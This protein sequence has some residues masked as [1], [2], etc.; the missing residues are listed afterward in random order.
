MSIATRNIIRL[1]C[2][3]AAI[4]LAATLLTFTVDPLQLFRP[5][6]FFTAMYS[7]D[8]RMQNAGLIRSQQFDT[9][10]MG[11]SLSIHVRPS[12][13]DRTLGVRSVKLAM[14]GSNSREHIFVLDTAME[15]R[16]RRVLWQMDDWIF[17][18]APDV[19]AY[20][21]ANLYR[22][23]VSGLAQYLLSGAM[24]R[25]SLW[26]ALR[27]FPTLA[28]VIT[29]LTNGV[30]FRFP[31]AEVDDINA[32]RR[33]L[34]IGAMYNKP[35]ALAGFRSIIDPSRR[36]IL[37]GGYD[38]DAMIQGFQRDAIGFITKHPDV[39]FDI[40]FAPYSIL[41]FV[42]LRDASPATLKT[43]YDFTAYAAERLT[44]LP[45]VRLYDFRAVREITHDLNDY[46][47]VAHYSPAVD[48][49]I[50][51]WLAEG[52]YRVDPKAPLASLEQLK[53]QVEAYR[54]EQP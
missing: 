52:K 33:D 9:V 44:Q 43:T 14:P 23:N 31:L 3:S 37:S 25:E 18:N 10:L 46:V 32:F 41:F 1:L 42:A 6:R 40:Y 54:V 35:K 12:D 20:L 47:D 29:K 4:V 5:A 51:S 19:D 53:A 45:N 28:P 15:R 27:A 17:R 30:M 26:I 36:K 8:T 39:Q 48:R 50:L 16:P 21:P 13:I 2:A 22:R 38:L 11:T 7:L 34:D 24:A 49:K